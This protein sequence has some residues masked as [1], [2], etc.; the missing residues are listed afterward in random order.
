MNDKSGPHTPIN[1]LIP[2]DEIRRAVADYMSSEGCGC[3]GDY[4]EHQAHAARLA[5]LL[6][7]PAY[8]DKSGFKFHEFES[9]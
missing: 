3:C 1:W 4:E 2:L 7:V 8:D 6:Q 9:K 5:E